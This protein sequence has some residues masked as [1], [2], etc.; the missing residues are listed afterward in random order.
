MERNFLRRSS[1][2]GLTNRGESTPCTKILLTFENLQRMFGGRLK[3]ARKTQS[4][5]VL[6]VGQI[7]TGVAVAEPLFQKVGP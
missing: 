3:V 2:N 5:V 4:W 1:L 7:G 6:G